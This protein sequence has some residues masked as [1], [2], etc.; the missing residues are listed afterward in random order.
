MMAA[1]LADGALIFHTDGVAEEYYHHRPSP[2]AALVE[3]VV[4]WWK[5]GASNEGATLRSGRVLDV[6][7]G[8]G[9]STVLFKDLMATVT[10]VDV[11]KEQVDR[12]KKLYGSS[13]VLNFIVG[14]AES[15]PFSAQ[16]FD[17]VTVCA[18]IHWFDL[19]QFYQQVDRVLCPGGVLA[20][21]S[22][23]DVH[24]HHCSIN[25]RPITKE[26][27]DALGFFSR[28]HDHLVA[29][30][31]DLPGPYA[32][33]IHIGSDGTE[34]R[35]SI[36]D[37]KKSSSCGT[38][39][40]TDGTRNDGEDNITIN[41]HHKFGVNKL[42]NKCEVEADKSE[43]TKHNFTLVQQGDLSS[44]RGYYASFAPLLRYAEQH[45]TNQA[46]ELLDAAMVRILEAIGRSDD[47]P[48][49]ELH[50]PYFLKMWR[51]PFDGPAPEPSSTHTSDGPAPEPSSSHTS[52]G[53]APKPSSAHT[54]DG[55]AL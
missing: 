26:F 2:P 37:E 9:Q 49:L 31:R 16:S 53:P 54:S 17:L 45:G 44:L 34:T 22:Y 25:L 35:S 24:P 18:S 1:N 19:E 3:T 12:A 15:L 10:G 4:N 27:R 48:P 41:E 8:T 7:C 32:E 36:A 21:Y 55:P 14:S 52:D 40:N 43:E 46:N 47:N 33:W 20:V 30:F 42:S 6:G 11:S 39:R 28:H 13:D 5:K 23:V 38:K 29:E 50:W 51:K